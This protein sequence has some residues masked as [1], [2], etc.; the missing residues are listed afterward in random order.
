M[1]LSTNLQ[2]GY[3]D[4]FSH[5]FSRTQQELNNNILPIIHLTFTQLQLS[6]MVQVLSEQASLSTNLNAEC[7]GKFTHDF[8]LDAPTQQHPTFTRLQPSGLVQVF[9]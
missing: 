6:V 4:N 3:Q 2:A 9:F 8:N 7:Q 1:S 5:D